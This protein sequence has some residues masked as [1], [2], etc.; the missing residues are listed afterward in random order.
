MAVYQMQINYVNNN[1][2]DVFINNYVGVFRRFITN[3]FIVNICGLK[4]FVSKD[5]HDVTILICKLNLLGFEVTI[6][7]GQDTI[8][9]IQV[10]YTCV[11]TGQHEVWEYSIENLISTIDL[12]SKTDISIVGILVMQIISKLICK[13]KTIYKAIILDLDETVWKG[14][15]AEDGIDIIKQNMHSNDAI[16]FLMFM[17]FIRTMAKELGLYVA[18]CSRNDSDKVQ[19][20]IEKLSEE[21]FPLK[22]QIDCIVANYND[23]SKNIK[24]IARQLSIL[25]NSCVFID[26]NQIVR[27]EVRKN[28]PEVFVPEWKN[29]NE[30]ITLLVSSC[31]FDRFELSLKSR[32]RKRLYEVLQQEREKGYLPQ[33]FVKVN[34]DQN[35]IQSKKLYARSNQ[36][37]L[38]SEQIDFSNAKSLF[39]EIYRSNGESLGICS[40]ITYSDVD[41]LTCSI[42]NWAVSCRYFEIG[43]EEFVIIYLLNRFPEKQFQF[44]CQFNKENAKIQNFINKYYGN[45]FTDSCDSVPV[46]SD[47][48]INHFVGEHSFY[49]HLLKIQKSKKDFNVYFFDSNYSSKFD[50]RGIELLKNNTK[51]QFL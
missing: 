38:V 49:K 21:E 35:H 31:V 41:T 30:L 12:S 50:L 34:D 37:K 44:A 46:D 43:L 23:K 10:E 42:L 27:D 6:S 15:L 7:D 4:D 18:I 48:F 3:K 39:F 14:T 1:Y 11:D 28:L 29:H 2:I 26:D 5:N 36:F 47:T 8:D 9:E 24:A 32:N 40:T 20:A 13:F 19:T 17:R 16:P 45:V 51:L 33:L 25:T 22:G